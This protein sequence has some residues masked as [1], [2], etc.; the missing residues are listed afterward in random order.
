MQQTEISTRRSFY[1]HVVNLL[2]A[3]MGA[4]IAVPAAGY[5]LRKPKSPASGSMVEVADV[6]KLAI[7]KPQEVVYLRA[8][9][10]GWNVTKEKTTAWVVKTDTHDVVAFSPQCTHLGCVYHW[11]SGGN[12]FV[13][14]CHASEFAMD[15][16]VLAGPAPRPLDRFASRIEGGKLLIGAEIE[17]T[18]SQRV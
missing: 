1:T 10:D 9:V 15:G 7:G 18:P 14:P 12:K 4:V 8:R 16:K 13:C 2:S 5:L 6:G 3:V 11:E 17:E